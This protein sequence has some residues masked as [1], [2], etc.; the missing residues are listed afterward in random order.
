[1]FPTRLYALNDTIKK[2][3]MSAGIPAL[4][5][6][7]ELDRRKGRRSDGMTI[8]PFSNGRGLICHATCVDTFDSGN[9]VIDCAEAVTLTAKVAQKAKRLKYRVLAEQ[10]IFEP[11]AFEATSIFRPSALQT[12]M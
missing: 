7:V 3:L 6:P 12:V 5:E 8:Y 1:M 2:T 11:F 9:D 4:L 10:R